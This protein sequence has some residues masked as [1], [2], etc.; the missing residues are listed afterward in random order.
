[1]LNEVGELTPVRIQNNLFDTLIL[2]P[3]IGAVQQSCICG[4]DGFSWQRLL[5]A[6]QTGLA[7]PSPGSI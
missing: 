3:A 1:M 2:A 4:S 6:I 7:L 5:C